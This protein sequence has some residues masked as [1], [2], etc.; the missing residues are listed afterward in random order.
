MWLVIR[1]YK[2]FVIGKYWFYNDRKVF[3]FFP[4]F[5]P[6]SLWDTKAKVEPK[7]CQGLD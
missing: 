4:P 3:Q 1:F 7:F 2:R 6:V 5:S